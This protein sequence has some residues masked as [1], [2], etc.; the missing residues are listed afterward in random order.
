MVPNL[1]QMNPVHIL[2]LFF[3]KIQFNIDFPSAGLPIHLSSGFLT[4]IL[5]AFLMYPYNIFF[6]CSPFYTGNY[7]N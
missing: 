7:K 5:Y 6:I 4:K 2:I 3:F 1:S